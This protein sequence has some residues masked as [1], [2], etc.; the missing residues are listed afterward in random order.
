ME[1]TWTFYLYYNIQGQIVVNVIKRVSCCF[2]M[3]FKAHI[4]IELLE[5][6]T[7]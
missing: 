4:L 1:H 2:Y 5:C 3:K 7:Q 6:I